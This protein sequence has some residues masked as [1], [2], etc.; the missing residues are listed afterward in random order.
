MEFPCLRYALY[1]RDMRARNIAIPR[2]LSG[3]SDARRGATVYCARC[4]QNLLSFTGVMNTYN[5]PL[6]IATT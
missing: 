4:R 2:S 1:W 5:F 3:H 6:F